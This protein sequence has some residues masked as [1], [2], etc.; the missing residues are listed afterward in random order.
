ME[1][2]PGDQRTPV[3]RVHVSQFGQR[4]S[5]HRF[6][7]IRSPHPQVQPSD[8]AEHIARIGSLLNSPAEKIKSFVEIVT[9]CAYLA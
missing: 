6:S 7:I 9:A 5:Q 1:F 8:P 3:L 4:F 2:L